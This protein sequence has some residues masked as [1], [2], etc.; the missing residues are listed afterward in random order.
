MTHVNPQINYFF[1]AR[2]A[3]GSPA[4]DEGSAGLPA[5]LALLLNFSGTATNSMTFLFRVCLRGKVTGASF[6]IHQSGITSHIFPCP[7][8]P[9]SARRDE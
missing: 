9:L 1:R 3:F 6:I 4:E 7:L 5:I 2:L 8:W